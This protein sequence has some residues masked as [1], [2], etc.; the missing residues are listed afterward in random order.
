MKTL[1]MTTL[2]LALALGASACGDRN[3]A[4]SAASDRIASERKSAEAL[5]DNLAGNAKAV[6][7][8]EAKG[9]A[10]I[11]Q[12]ELTERTAPS[13]ENRLAV[14]KA[15][16]DAA[17][18]VA[19]V[20]CDAWSGNPRDVCRKEADQQYAAATADA[21]L[22]QEMK[23]VRSTAREA[24]A[25]V[26]ETAREAT[27]EARLDAM[28]TKRDAEYAVEMQKCD[29]YAGDMR[30]TCIERVKAEFASN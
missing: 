3:S 8:E 5:C 20:R 25:E 7:L 11:A 21:Q 22:V 9:R 15:H 28:K 24:S 14:R 2:C 10:R 16:A 13:D 27:D 29:G 23:D 6:C 26:A 12:A 19:L 17:L 30:S 1:H 18:A 4:S